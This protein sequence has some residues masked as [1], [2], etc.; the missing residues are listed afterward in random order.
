[1]D[2]AGRP[3]PAGAAAR[4]AERPTRV[5]G[6]IRPDPGS[7]WSPRSSWSAAWPSQLAALAARRTDLDAGVCRAGRYFPA[8]EGRFSPRT[9]SDMLLSG[10]IP[11]AASDRSSAIS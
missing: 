9:I 5:L 11:H 2:G 3:R 6:T 4:R 1:V 8:G 10:S 7:R